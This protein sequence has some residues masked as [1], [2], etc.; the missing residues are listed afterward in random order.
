M[1]NFAFRI[2][3]NPDGIQRLIM[4]DGVIV[5]Y[6]DAH[7]AHTWYLTQGDGAPL[8]RRYF[9]SMDAAYQEAI[10]INSKDQPK[11]KSYAAQRA[12]EARAEGRE[13]L[14]FE[15]AT[16][17][18]AL[19]IIKAITDEGFP[20]KLKQNPTTITVFLQEL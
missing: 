11:I 9:D 15:P 3:A 6:L 7:D 17:E 13:T 20:I 19:E 14:E 16:T 1:S 18:L 12:L 8:E 2:A 4:K 5:A 10:R